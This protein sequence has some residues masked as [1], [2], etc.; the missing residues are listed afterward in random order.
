[1]PEIS[2]RLK[3]IADLV[4]EGA[5]VCDVGTD[6]GYLA[7]YLL[8]ERNAARVIATDLNEK[9]L[10]RAKEN[11]AAAGCEGKI[12]LRLCDGLNGVSNG[13]IDTAVIAGMGG[14][15][16][17]DILT[18]AP[19]VKQGKLLILHPASKAPHLRR[20]CMENGLGVVD[21]RIVREGHRLYP[22]LVVR[23]DAPV[24]CDIRYTAASAPV[25]ASNDEAAIEYLRRQR[26]YLSREQD[27][28][29]E[30]AA[31]IAALDER[32]GNT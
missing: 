18:A 21:E 4:R 17:A 12:E 2:I 5:K 8:K 31:I 20:W 9:P 26:L 1:M 32:L 22:I 13:E 11:I 14:E 23:G 30:N 29:A 28:Q 7:I 16:I 3:T 27:N 15:T 25:W 24:R 6:H 19:W 10:S